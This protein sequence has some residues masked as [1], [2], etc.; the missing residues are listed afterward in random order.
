MES[1]QQQKAAPIVDLDL[2]SEGE[3]ASPK[4]GR[5]TTRQLGRQLEAL[6]NETLPDLIKT[7]LK[8]L[9]D[10]IEDQM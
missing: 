3:G 5:V 9:Q 4:K 8:E 6:K 1:I 10:T 7:S 2:D